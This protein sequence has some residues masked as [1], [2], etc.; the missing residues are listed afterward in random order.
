MSIE[1]GA[2]PRQRLVVTR[3]ASDGFYVTDVNEAEQKNGYNSLFAFNFSIPP[4]MRVCD[5]VTY[6]SGTVNEFFGFTELSFPSY[7]LR[8]PD[9]GKEPCLVPE[10]TIL[11]AAT[12]FSASGMEKL[13]SG[14]VRVEG[15]HIARNFGPRIAKNNV[16]AP[17]QSNCDLNNDG[18]VDFNSAAEG[19]CGN[20]CSADPDCSEWT[21]FSARGNYKLSNPQGTVMIQ[22]QTGA[23]VGF[24]PVA[25][26]GKTLKAVAGTLRNFSGGSINWTIEARCSD[27][28]VCDASVG[29]TCDGCAGE[30]LSS[31]KACVRSRS[32][33]DNDQGTN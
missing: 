15:Y 3:V 19:S 33:D 29:C 4:G 25:N 10:P 8:Y 28:I 6:L 31:Q 9:L 7:Q 27:D 23:A 2:A 12:I 11:D 18:Q 13:E 16:F 26:R 20:A 17:E 32:E 30:P 14:L 22:L 1:I 21:S 24:D 5:E